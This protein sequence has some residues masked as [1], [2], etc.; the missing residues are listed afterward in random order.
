MV[1][2]Y[3][4]L[5]LY[6]TTLTKESVCIKAFERPRHLALNDWRKKFPFTPWNVPL[7]EPNSSTS[8]HSRTYNESFP[9][10]Q[11]LYADM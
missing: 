2:F 10:I 3:L 1:D 6:F 9:G 11:D 8:S 7:I 4:H 5:P